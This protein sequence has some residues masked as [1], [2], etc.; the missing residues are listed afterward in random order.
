MN[1]QD[2]LQ[3]W[4]NEHNHLCKTFIFKDFQQ[5]FAF[6]TSVAEVSEERKHHPNWENTYNRVVIRLQTHDENAI[7]EKD[8][9]L[10]RCIDDLF[11]QVEL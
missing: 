4:T 10:A 5:A 6:M 9:G 8:R 3:S 7:T 11:G 2:T 1:T